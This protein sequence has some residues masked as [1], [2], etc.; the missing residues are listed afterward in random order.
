MECFTVLDYEVENRIDPHFY[1]PEFR[2]L[3][4]KLGKLKNQKL[5]L[6][7]EFSNETWNQKD[8]FDSEFPYIE[9]SEIDIETGEIRNISYYEKSKAPSRAKMIVRENDIIVSTTRPHRGAISL[10]D[11][12][13]NGFI[14]STGFAILRKIKPD[15]VKRE[16]F[17]FLLRTQ[18]SLKQMLQRSSGGNY[19]AIT[20]EELKNIIIPIPSLE[21]QDKIIELMRKAYQKQKERE[22]KAQQF[23]DSINNY[24]LDELGIKLPE[25]KD[26]MVYIV[27]SEEVQNK[28][29]DAYY[30][31]PKFEEVEKAIKKG[32]FEVKELKEVI[33]FIPGYAFSSNDYV[34]NEGIKLLTIRNIKENFID[35]SD[36][37]LLPNDFFEKY[38][39]FQIK[40][41]DIVI[42]MTGATIGKSFIF[43]FDDKV[44]LN[45]RVGII[46]AKEKLNKYFLLSFIK[47]PLFKQKILRQ[48]CG[49]AQP[50]ISEYEITSIKIPLPP[51][52]IQN[53]IA[54]EVKKRMQK[55][56]QLQKEAKE[57][58]GKA[59]KEVEQIILGG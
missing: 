21:T 23:L 20:S 43:N 42:A 53:K 58:L 13:K 31:Q 56:E 49:G 11:K 24:V 16:Y 25:L 4:N 9:I 8:L 55:A 19:P 5:G 1:R 17:L 59:K 14:A 33:D 57:K 45:Q 41:E 36:T 47:T 37:T 46:R 28:R 50:N 54:E 30:Y 15:N 12:E 39:K 7:I 18:L 52:S 44:L 32:K 10:I 51:L 27:N 26:K 38:D 3:K 29:A 48:S 2:K 22:A 6:I 40:N 35:L 34:Y